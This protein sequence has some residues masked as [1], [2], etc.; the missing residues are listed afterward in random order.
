VTAVTFSPRGMGDQ[1]DTEPIFTGG[2]YKIRLSATQTAG[3][4]VLPAWSTPRQLTG[5]L[6]TENL[7]PNPTIPYELLMYVPNGG[8][9]VGKL[10]GMLE[11]H[12]FRIVAGAGP[13]AW[14]SLTLVTG[15][16]GEAV[17]TGTQ[18]AIN[19]D[20]YAQI[21][22]VSGGAS[23]LA[24]VS[25]ISTDAKALIA[26]PNSYST[27]RGLLGAA[28]TVS[29]TFT[30]ALTAANPTFTGTVTVPDGSLTIAD[31]NGL[32]VALDG[33]A[34]L[35]SPAFTGNPTA[36]TPTAGD[37]DTSIATTA[38]V[39]TAIAGVSGGGGAPLVSPAFTGNP[40]APTPTAGD[41]DTS[42]ATT[43]FV[44]TA[45]TGVPS[46][47]AIDDLTTLVTSLTARV[48]ELEENGANMSAIVGAAAA[49]NN[50]L[51]GTAFNPGSVVTWLVD[52]TAPVNAVTGDIVLNR[53]SI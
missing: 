20:L 45:L 36:P 24:A 4:W 23:S 21:G 13:V 6:V 31:T 12:E 40:T 46:Q 34:P 37:N 29:P 49:R 19:A 50:P 32:Q 47:T 41:N 2:F 52:G 10:G 25:G 15:P 22:S 8:V 27:M 42:I 30:T 35:S 5:S 48:Q 51:T 1:T 18:A 14:E 43:A 53:V 33:K 26:T 16:A 17:P 7:D 44:A 3:Q 38:F 28:P 11:I 39:Q 9:T